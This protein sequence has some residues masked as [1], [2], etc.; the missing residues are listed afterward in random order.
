MND[1]PSTAA[2]TLNAEL[3]AFCDTLWLEHGLARNTLAGY[4]S[5]LTLFGHWLSQRGQTLQAADAVTLAAYLAEFSQRAKPTSQRRLLSAWRRYYRHLL[6][7]HQISSDPTLKLDPP[8]PT[9]RL[10]KTLTE[11]QVEALL[12]APDL[13]SPLGIRDRCMLEVIYASGLRVSE[14]ITLPT[15]AVSLND[16]V[17]K[18]MGKGSKERLVPLGQIAADWIVR[19]MRES[20]PTLLAGRHCDAMFVTK[21]GAAMSRQMFWR[22]IKQYATQAGIPAQRISPHTLRHA[23]ATHLLNHGA[24]LRVVQLL[25]GHADISTTQVYTHVARERLKALHQHHHPRA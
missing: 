13:D 2:Q 3:D 15:F 9:Q 6:A 22:I 24:D 5:D 14:L 4:R 10:P 1:T 11:S 8:L 12:A 20:R 18:V 17:V 19:Y 25:L 21:H 16:G 23:F 7:N